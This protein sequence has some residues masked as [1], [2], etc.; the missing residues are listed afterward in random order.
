MIRSICATNM[1]SVF[2][3]EPER[4]FDREQNRTRARMRVCVCVVCARTHMLGGMGTQ[5]I[6][7]LKPVVSYLP[8]QIFD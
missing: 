7:G 3:F 5:G 6:T 8:L 1:S 2:L 4:L